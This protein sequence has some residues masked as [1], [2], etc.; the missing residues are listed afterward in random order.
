VTLW[1]FESIAGFETL[2][3]K[4]TQWYLRLLWSKYQQAIRV[5]NDITRLANEPGVSQS[6]IFGTSADGAIAVGS[7]LTDS[8]LRAVAWHSFADAR[9]LGVLHDGD[10]CKAMPINSAGTVIVGQ[11]TDGANKNYTM[12]FRWTASTGMQS[13]EDWIRQSAGDPGLVG[14][15]QG[16]GVSSDGSRVVGALRDASAFMA[17]VPPTRPR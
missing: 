17:V 16:L 10:S 2:P 8:G 12:V 4:L 6:Q 15:N 3:S 13:L 14:A 5:K 1:L 9:Q 11:A 7:Q